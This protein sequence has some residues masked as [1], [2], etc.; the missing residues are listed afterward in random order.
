MI[1]VSIIYS[2]YHYHYGI[3]NRINRRFARDSFSSKKEIIRLICFALFHTQYQ[4]KKNV[5]S[6]KKNYIKRKRKKMI[7][8][9]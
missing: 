7:I 6:I 2:P 8:R 3:Q 1:I 5:T 9:Y 4:C